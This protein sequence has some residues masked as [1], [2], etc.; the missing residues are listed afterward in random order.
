MRFANWYWIILLFFLPY[1][2]RLRERRKPATVPHPDLGWRVRER[3]RNLQLK[4]RLPLFLR[5]LAVALL[6][7]ALARPQI[8]FLADTSNRYGV[9][10]M[11]ALDISSSMTAEDFAPNRITVAK[12]VL[13]D[14]I[15]ARPGDR[16]GLI[17]F[18]SQSYVQSPLTPD[19]KTLLSFLSEVKVGMAEDGTAVG[20][21]LANA[22][23]RLKDSKAKSKLILLLTDG[24]NN[25]GAID[26]ATAAKLAATYGIKIYAIGIGNP[27]GSPIPIIDQFGQKEYARNTDGS[28]FLT[29][30]NGEGLKNV[31]A[32]TSGSYFV[33]SDSGKLSGI[34]SEIDRMEKTRYE[35][36]S[37]YVY[38]EK[39]VRFAFP[40]L[41]LLFAEF[42][43]IRFWLRVV[44]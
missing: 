10:I 25:A 42:I 3:G 30:M 5:L 28:L 7:L 6:I 1:L 41:L 21:A 31:A 9:D 34:F 26:P 29:K 12:R 2:Y 38:D 13:S 19:H 17:V 32:L 36:K 11:V 16:I 39:F 15:G 43:I 37:P 40:A 8:G 20:M 22:V 14:F 23:K 27:A 4:L 44:P 24:D 18:G 33:A 35:A